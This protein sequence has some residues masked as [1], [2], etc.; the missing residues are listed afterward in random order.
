M[1]SPQMDLIC[2]LADIAQRSG[3]TLCRETHRSAPRTSRL[4]QSTAFNLRHVAQ[5][6]AVVA[7]LLEGHEHPLERSYW[8]SS[9]G[10]FDVGQHTIILGI[11]A[12]SD[13]CVRMGGLE[14]VLK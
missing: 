1:I 5:A 8:K 2:A 3:C 6:I 14:R 4:W 12:Q 13:L 7:R 9:A 10:V 11:R